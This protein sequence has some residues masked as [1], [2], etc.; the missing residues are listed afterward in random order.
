M[1][2]AWLLL[3]KNRI[4]VSL[5]KISADEKQKQNNQ[6]ATNRKWIWS[7]F[8]NHRL[9]VTSPCGESVVSRFV[10]EQTKV[11]YG[12]R[13]SINCHYWKGNQRTQTWLLLSVKSHNIVAVW[14]VVSGYGSQPFL[15][16]GR[17][18]GKSERRD[19][20]QLIIVAVTIHDTT[21]SS[22]GFQTRLRLEISAWII[23]TDFTMRECIRL[24][25]IIQY[26]YPVLSTPKHEI[27]N[28]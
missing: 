14:N 23:S 25:S 5:S 19:P 21:F 11:E 4:F 12:A 27:Q 17:I 2:V 24:S 22:H 13:R 18:F 3:E 8:Q 7:S 20:V 1:I 10:T 26:Y 6:N 28:I 16:L 15:P 9:S